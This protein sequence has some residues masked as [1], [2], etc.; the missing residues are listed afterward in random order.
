MDYQGVAVLISTISAVII[1]LGTFAMQVVGAIQREKMKV[2]AKA[3]DVKLAQVHDLVNGQSEKMAVISK[4]IGFADGEKAG[5]AQERA[6][7]MV[8]FIT[9]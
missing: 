5:Q 1:S 6:N 3:T 9:K 7:P 2:A 4:A 8:P